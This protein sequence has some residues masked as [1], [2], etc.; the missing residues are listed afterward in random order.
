MS[1]TLKD[2]VLESSV[3]T[4]TG[5]FVL[6]GAQTGYQGFLVTGDGSQIPY[7]IQGKNTDGSLNGEWEV[8]I[9]TYH[10][11]GNYISRDTVL[12]SS[13]SNSKVPFAV[14]DK[15]V[16]LDLP[17][18]LVV[19]GPSSATNGNLAVFD[20][21]TG[22]VLKDN[23]Y[24]VGAANGVASLD[25]SGKVPLSQIPALGDLNYQGAWN[26]ST[27]TPTLTSSVG[28]KGYYYVVS[29]SGSTNLNG[30]TDWVVGDWA[31]FNG[32]IWQKIDNTDAG[33]DVVGPSSATDN[34]IV[35]F[36]GT[37]GKLIQSSAVTIDDAG[38]IV[39]PDSV[40]FSGTVPATQP[41]GTLW[42]DS[43]NDSLNLQ[44]NN[45]IQQIG[46]EI[47]IYGRASNDITD[48]QVIAVSG[49]YGTSGFVTFEPAPIGTTDPTHIIGL[50][51]EPIAKNG[52]GRITAFGIVHGLSTSPG[53]AD[54]DALWYDPTVVGGYT[55][56]QP[57]APN[58]KVQIG[59]V[60]KA[61][62]GT[63]GSIQVKV[64]NGPTI[65][66]IAN[67][68]VATPTGGQLLTYNATGGY[69]K[70]TSL[71]AGTAITVT[72]AAG[73]GITITNSAPDQTVVLTGAGTTTVTGTY[74]NFTITSNDAYT[75]TVTS[76]GMTVPT[77]L[78]VT[79]TPITTSGTLAL[80]FTTGYS[81][82]TTA[83]QSNWDSA[84]TQRLQWDGGS[85]N[86]VSATGRTSLGATTLG[87]NIFTITN[88]S[89]VTF[90]RFNADNT[91][92]ALDAATFRT[93]IGAGTS[94]TTGTVT[95]VAALT[96]GTTG[97][98]LSSTVATSTTT[99]VIT[100]NVPTASATNRGALSSTDW[101]TF[102][103]K[104]AALVSG[105]N[106]KTVNGTT[107]LGS[108]D[109]GTIGLG[110]GGTG[111]TTAPAANANLFG[112]T[113]TATA[114]G[115][116][117]LT[118]TSSVY[119]LFTGTTTQTVVLPVTSTLTQ[120]WSFHIENSSTGNL[121]VNS[122]GGNLVIT[123]LP[124]TTA[125]IT[126]I[127]NSGTT[128]ASW[129]A[130]LTDFGA[131][132]STQS[133]YLTSTDWTTFNNKG[134]GTVTGVT[135]TAPVV[136]SGGTAPIISMAAATTSVNGYLTSTDW[137]T[138]N[139]KAPATSGTSILYG[140]G[141]GGFSNVTIGSGLTFST[142]ILT[143]T[144]SN[145]MTTLGD[146]MYG[147]A[148]GVN[149]RLP[150]NT[151]TAKQFLSQTGTGTASAAPA[152]SALPTVLPVLN[153]A[154]STV[155]VSVGNGVLPVLTHAGATVNVAVN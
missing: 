107:L 154:G 52:F 140:N 149:T 125:M 55:K 73:G 142:G 46:E 118:N 66:D 57:S 28:T 113:S 50:A 143:A 109:L 34:A 44:Q 51:T 21:T 91:I 133:G 11:S 16:F 9:G 102:N 147:A 88:P 47:Y 128:A 114:A 40:Q 2:R 41:I 99:P 67:I 98:D 105:T 96:L 53:Y 87:A 22:K 101:S 134:L 85:T 18:E 6:T 123:V 86:L 126:C 13:N 90:P 121:T 54:G 26:A 10:L 80:T 82:P 136:S 45:I 81:I 104:Q 29:V 15:D 108:G 65:N 127:L 77:G 72:P 152:W 33:G 43:S 17:G 61:A 58:I 83:S 130:G 79:G 20:G 132:S 95:S 69:W 93:A 25:S 150:G 36:D 7:T 8:G 38:N 97:T 42:F 129:E 92:S 19:Q 78:T 63:N 135:A 124:N 27:N 112:F 116:T 12:E 120:G 115:T 23:G 141:S 39:S 48:G 56:T 24:A 122:S 155:S 145:P 148:S 59:V 103:G 1:Y 138:F 60:T 31:V 84:Y 3:S 110:Y 64:F 139:G 5:D 119:Q 4:G 62:G 37:T 131:A 146:T 100:L 32:T 74:P 70:N 89:A 111:A 49:A 75:G 144:V 14:G 106:I 71:T 94:S 76:V 30:I 35:R 68:Q 117:T 137:N 153:R 151:T